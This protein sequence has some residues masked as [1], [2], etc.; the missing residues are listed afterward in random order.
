MPISQ[1]KRNIFFYENKN[2]NYV[3]FLKSDFWRR[4]EIGQRRFKG[5]EC[6]AYKWPISCFFNEFLPTMKDFLLENITKNH[7][8][9][10]Q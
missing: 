10:H 7:G 5:Y 6:S 4:N 8:E 9:R 2:M 1:Y 3:N